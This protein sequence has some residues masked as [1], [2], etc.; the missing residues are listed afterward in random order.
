M[1]WKVLVHTPA[2]SAPRERSM[3]SLRFAAARSR[4]DEDGAVA[5]VHR[6]H[7]FGIETKIL[8]IDILPHP[9]A[10]FNGGAYHI[11]TMI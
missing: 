1:E 2:P 4:D 3:R 11:C 8:H 5:V 9:D 10:D 7:L 6:E